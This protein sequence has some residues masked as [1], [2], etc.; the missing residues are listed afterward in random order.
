MA[1]CGSQHHHSER[2]TLSS[3][4]TPPSGSQLSDQELRRVQLSILDEFT[5][6]C[7]TH[8][9]R[10]MLAYG[11]LLG[12]ARHQG[13][14]PWDD[15]IDLMMPRADYERLRASERVG[16]FRV[17][18]SVH[19]GRWFFPIIKIWDES[20]AVRGDAPDSIDIGVNIDV[21]P[22]DEVADGLLSR[23]Q[24]VSIGMLNSVT[25]LQAVVPQ[26]NRTRRK[27]LLLKLIQPLARMLPRH[28]LLHLLDLVAKGQTSGGTQAG[29]L[30]GPYQW[31]IPRDG[32]TSRTTV[33]FEGRDLP[34]PDDVT[35]VLTTVYGPDHMELPP[36]ASRQTHH[37]FT[38]YWR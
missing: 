8:D 35:Q 36:V 2:R 5:T 26:A 11:T 15:D 33:S 23:L 28:R 9:L 4:P 34:A 25:A 12:A 3:N 21:F 22:I 1:R 37:T 13:Y 17:G 30:V 7:S 29:V 18:S 24:S 27:Q 19:D 20:T 16:R 6:W 32:L 31:T 10:W 38:A 14:I